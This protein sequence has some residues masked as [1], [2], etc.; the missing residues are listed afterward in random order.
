[1]K[2][3]ILIINRQRLDG[4]F[5]SAYASLVLRKRRIVDTI[6]LSESNKNSESI[7][8]YKEMGIN[9]VIFI[10]NEYYKFK[11]FL[12]ILKSLLK[13]IYILYKLTDKKFELSK[14]RIGKINAGNLISDHLARYHSKYFI[15]KFLNLETFKLLFVIVFRFL[16]ISKIIK[17][18]SIKITILTSWSYASISNIGL[19]V[20][21]TLKSKVLIITGSNY[22]IYKKY[23]DS[24]IDNSSLNKSALD[25]IIFGNKKI[26]N[27]SIKYFQERIDASKLKGLKES[28]VDKH[29]WDIIRSFYKKK[30]LTKDEFYKFFNLKNREKKICTIAL[31][32]FRDANHVQGKLLFESF[33]DEFLETLNFIENNHNFYW[34]VKPHPTSK[35]YGESGLVEGILKKKNIKNV[36]IIPENINTKTV[37]NISD[38][39]VTPRGTIALE[40]AALGKKPIISAETYFSDY[41]F[42][43]KA[44]TKKEY[45]KLISD[46]NFPIVN[47]TNLKNYSKLI[48]YLKKYE[49]VEKNIYNFTDPEVIIGKK[50]FLSRYKKIKSGLF[51][52]NNNLFKLYNK[53]V[54][55]V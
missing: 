29:N 54:S 39:I 38:K 12:I 48:L 3:K 53:M 8:F 4:V 26:L 43:I 36:I 11:N 7:K 27:R 31:H 20:S 15:K 46:K 21:L 30:D 50:V 16:I 40:F 14:Y 13:T 9:K 51:D 19:R 34:F 49:L 10:K 23:K 33:Y 32:A 41:K 17:N 37:L 44:N 52:Q 18:E 35:K 47:K 42:L 5:R 55:E 28:Q 45:F 2:E 6:V 1:M 22:M 24:L 25:K